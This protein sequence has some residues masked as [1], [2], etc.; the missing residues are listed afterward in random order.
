MVVLKSW[1]AGVEVLAGSGMKMG[2]FGCLDSGNTN[3]D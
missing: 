1:E 2:E 3:N